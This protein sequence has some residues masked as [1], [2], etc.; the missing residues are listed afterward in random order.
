MHYY[1]L[2]AEEWENMDLQS[3]WPHPCSVLRQMKVV[4]LAETV[5]AANYIRQT[6]IL[7]CIA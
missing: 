4:S 1:Y 7:I 6:P 5:A 3:L 2:V